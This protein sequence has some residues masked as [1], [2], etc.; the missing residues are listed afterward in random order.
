MKNYLFLNNLSIRKKLIF[1][2]STILILTGVVGLQASRGL[3]DAESRVRK[4]LKIQTLE[5][6]ISR[7]RSNEKDYLLTKDS[8]YITDLKNGVEEIRKDIASVKEEFTS[9]RNR[10][11]MNQVDDSIEKYL[12]IFMNYTGIED[13]KRLAMSEMRIANK[14]ALEK[15]SDIDKDQNEQLKEI[16]SQGERFLADK[17]SKVE[18]AN[19]IL[20]NLYQARTLRIQLVQRSTNDV[21]KKWK[22]KNNELFENTRELKSRFILK[23]NILQANRILQVYRLYE[24]EMLSYLKSKNKAAYSSMIKAALSAEK[25]ILEIVKDQK[26]QLEDARKENDIKVRDKIRKA[27]GANEIIKHFL[28]ARKNEKEVIISGKDKYLVLVRDSIDR[29]LSTANDLKK[30]FI[31]Q[32]NINQID[33]VIS[34]IV[35]YQVDFEQYILLTKDQKKEQIKLYNSANEAEKLIRRTLSYQEQK[36]GEER[37]Y[38]NT[39]IIVV[40]IAAMSLGLVLSF[41]ISDNISKPLTFAASVAN[42]LSSGDTNIKLHIKSNDET[43]QLL[44]SMKDM[45]TQLDLIQNNSKDRDWIKTKQTELGAVMRTESDIHELL[46]NALSFFEDALELQ[47]AAVFLKEDDSLKIFAH[48]GIKISDRNLFNVKEGEGIV[49]QCASH[50][51]DILLEG[52]ENYELKWEVNLGIAT[53]NLNQILCTPLIFENTLVGVLVLGKIK[54]FSQIHMDLV[55]VS[56]EPVSI[57]INSAASQEQMKKLLNELKIQSEELKESKLIAEEADHAKS[58]FLA[59]MSHEIRTPMNAIIGMA[60]LVSNTDLNEKQYDYVAK[61]QHSANN[62]LGIINDILDYSKI[63]AGKMAIE[64]IE[65]NLLE[66]LNNLIPIIS[67]KASEKNIE[68]LVKVDPEIPEHLIGD[69]LRISQ[70]LINLMNN[71]IKFTEEGEVILELI[72]RST[73]NGKHIINFSVRDTGLGMTPGQVSRLFQSFNQADTSTTRK[74]GGTGLGLKISKEFVNMMGGEIEVDSKINE[75]SSFKFTLELQEASTQ[76]MSSSIR[77]NKS[78]EGKRML[79]VEDHEISCEILKDIL[80]SFN[81]EVVAVETGEKG[82][83]ELRRSHTLGK[84]YDFVLMDWKLPGIDGVEATRIIKSDKTMSVTPTVIMVSAFGDEAVMEKA[85]KAGAESFLHKPV[86]ASTVLDSVLRYVDGG[87]EFIKRDYNTGTKYVE[88]I[89]GIENANVLLVEDNI[90]NQEIA[91]TFLSDISL[92]VTIA[93]NGR[94]AVDL[95]FANDYDCVLMDVQMPVMD[96]YEATKHIREDGRFNDLPILAM[97]ASAMLSDKEEAL[98]VG[99]ND[100]IAKPIDI[101]V[102]Y[103]ALVKWIKPNSEDKSFKKNELNYL[104]GINTK[105]ALKAMDGRVD[106]YKRMLW[107]FYEKYSDTLIELDTLIQDDKMNDAIRYIHSLRGAALSIGAIRIGELSDVLE[108]D[109]EL[110]FENYAEKVSELKKELNVVISSMSNVDLSEYDDVA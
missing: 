9:E 61:I 33:S 69:P 19:V 79:I 99:M 109:E 67:Q 29:V 12:S 28:D 98:H 27:S 26:R 46:Y 6:D 105:V 60:N 18:S 107:K 91:E 16:R 108:H 56:T 94:E 102:L 80:E 51:K 63:E 22:L 34:A 1:A 24:N 45:I 11:R 95:V 8:K 13:K 41:L 64:N 96:G 2:F 21:L 75:G 3:E 31:F 82:V 4:T 44:K 37:E 43:G 74:Y 32:K 50:Q 93:N 92:N 85:E 110:C 25:E 42:R 88:G 78:I 30:S 15:A 36:R 52:D 103:R 90:I 72:N 35:D 89:S 7:I 104:K 57:A 53:M 87:H 17:L 86:T 58:E 59:N 55:K 73:H 49:G 48:T 10:K 54:P 83:E 81:C 101:N 97:T 71:A 40:T 38:S 66:V 14:L 20:R 62:L 77:N 5:D 65:F 106:F 70:I 39:V 68:L 76:Y 84:P 47:A 100:H 23:N